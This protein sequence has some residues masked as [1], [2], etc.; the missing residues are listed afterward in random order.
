MFTILSR[1]LTKYRT[2][3]QT[4]YKKMHAQTL[5][6][7]PR[8]RLYRLLINLQEISF[9][10]FQNKHVCRKVQSKK[11]RVNIIA[12]HKPGLLFIDL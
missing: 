9:S 6:F 8:N 10:K 7:I 5:K 2:F 4:L 12:R 11:L 1:N 3:E